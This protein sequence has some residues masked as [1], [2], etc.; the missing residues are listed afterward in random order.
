MHVF[1]D[2]CQAPVLP[3]SKN[4]CPDHLNTSKVDDIAVVIDVICPLDK[5][6]FAQG[7]NSAWTLL[8]DIVDKILKEER[9]QPASTDEFSQLESMTA[10]A[11]KLM[12]H[13]RKWVT[14][15]RISEGF[16]SE[17]QV[18]GVSHF[19]SEYGCQAK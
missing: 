18:T 14:K 7:P 4:T 9:R 11:V 1:I 6:S 16:L 17:A 19:A 2:A 15:V 13:M 3:T 5:A 12:P 10:G 8:N